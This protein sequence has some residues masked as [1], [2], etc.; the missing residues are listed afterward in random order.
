MRKKVAIF[1]IFK[2]CY[3][4]MPHILAYG[5]KAQFYI[6]KGTRSYIYLYCSIFQCLDFI[7]LYVSPKRSFVMSIGSYDYC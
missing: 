5:F 1:T 6:Q 7:E 3:A 2:S 4:H